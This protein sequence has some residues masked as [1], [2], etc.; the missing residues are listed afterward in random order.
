M[1]NKSKVI[2]IIITIFIFISCKNK[3]KKESIEL[4]ISQIETIH[5]DSIIILK[6]INNKDNKVAIL[7]DDKFYN[8]ASNSNNSLIQY[9]LNQIIMSND[10]KEE[11]ISISSPTTPIKEKK[12][13][14]KYDDK[15]IFLNTQINWIYNDYNNKKNMITLENAGKVS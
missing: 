11:I 5:N 6:I 2:L 8:P 4:K 3:V 14:K 12:V 10:S 9:A 1:E 15:N 7:I 13:S